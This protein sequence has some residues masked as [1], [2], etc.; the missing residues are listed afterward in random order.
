MKSGND[1]PIPMSEEQKFFFDLRGWI[2]LPGV[3]SDDEIAAMKAEAFAAVD[4]SRHMV[5]NPVSSYQGTLQTLLDH[6]AI[7]G[8]LSEILA[9][10]RFLSDDYYAFRCESSF[11]TVR[12]PGWSQ[13]E[14]S[15]G[16][17]PHVVRPP[18]QA[19]AM[20]YQVA[21]RKIFAGLTRVVWE[22][23]EVKAGHGG[24]SFLSGSHKA[25]FNY[26]GPDP[27]RPNISE[28]MWENN[29]REMMEDY[30]C[31]PGS[32]VVF[33][34]SLLHAAND[35]T[36]P[37]NPRCAV[38]NCYNSLW[39]QWHRMNLDHAIIEAMPPKRR[40]LFRGVWQIG[41]QNDAY[42]IDNRSL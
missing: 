22:L 18:Q 16:G 36:N 28:S 9:E 4:P 27:Y 11:I 13:R 38:F 25:H 20:R 40:S 14:R 1:A 10:E 19:N 35:W 7:V 6:P 39:A 8:I 37:D 42:S 17:L 15:D 34:E 24:T 33:T 26:G 29:I 31:P 41:G 23:E 32:A 3:L 21:G 5:I 12:S 2:L 30:S